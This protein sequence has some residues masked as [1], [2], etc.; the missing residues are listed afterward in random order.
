MSDAQASSWA[1]AL[2]RAAELGLQDDGEH[3]AG[4]LYNSL[5]GCR[6][7]TADVG[8]SPDKV[9]NYLLMRHSGQ[10]Q[11]EPDLIGR[12]NLTATVLLKAARLLA[13]EGVFDQDLWRLDGVPLGAYLSNDFK[14]FAD[15]HM[16]DGENLVWCIGQDIFRV[17][18]VEASWPNAVAPATSDP[19]LMAGAAMASLLYPNRVPWFLLD[20]EV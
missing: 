19:V 8:I 13:L 17:R 3:L 15:R 20:R 7:Q 12:P 10:F 2:A 18:D 11:A 14:Q 16:R 5:A 4:L 9:L 6:G 1:I